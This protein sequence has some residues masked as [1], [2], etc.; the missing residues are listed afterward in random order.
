MPSHDPVTSPAHYTVYPVQPISI[1][2]Y[3]GFNLGNAVKYVLRAPFKGEEEDLQKAIQYLEWE[4]ETPSQPVTA[5]AY[6]FCESALGDLCEYLLDNE[7]GYSR[8]QLAFLQ[9]VDSYIVRG[10]ADDLRSMI[11]EIRDMLAAMEGEVRAV[12]LATEAST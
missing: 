4:R 5:W 6:R 9:Y 1:T 7:P 12:L 8:Y 2:R 11:A 3:L 10:S